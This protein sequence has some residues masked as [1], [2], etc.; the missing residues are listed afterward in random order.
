VQNAL[1]PA[2][3]Q[4]A[5]AHALN[6]AAD[7]LNPQ[8]GAKHRD[9]THV[10]RQPALTPG[11]ITSSA[12]PHRRQ[13]PA[14]ATYHNHHILHS[15]FHISTVADSA[16]RY[17]LSLLRAM[18]RRAVPTRL[19][20]RCSPQNTLMRQGDRPRPQAATVHSLLAH[21][22]GRQAASQYL[23]QSAPTGHRAPAVRRLGLGC[24]GPR[25]ASRSPSPRCRSPRRRGPGRPTAGCRRRRT[26]R[27]GC[28]SAAAA[29]ARA[30]GARAGRP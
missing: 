24:A 20:P 26:T 21:A 5:K 25:T 22:A 8:S 28:A 19:P 12:L 15:H 23:A 13:P 9:V 17:L 18:Q 10:R 4:P 11:C 2:A 1:C 29:A 6:T 14:A 30:R 16:S 27:S 7:L 3:L